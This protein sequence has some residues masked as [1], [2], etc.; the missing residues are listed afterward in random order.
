[1]ALQPFGSW[2]IFQ[3]LNLTHSRRKLLQREISPLQG[4]LLHIRTTQTQNKCTQTSMSQVEFEPM[5]PVFEL[6]M[7]V[8]ALDN[9][10]TVIG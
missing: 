4:R 9:A 1:M 10:A 2:T 7:I 8:H 5:I 3:F 6:A